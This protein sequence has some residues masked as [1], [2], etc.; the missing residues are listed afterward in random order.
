MFPQIKR[1]GQSR[2]PE[3]PKTKEVNIQIWPYK[4]TKAVV[5]LA[6]NWNRYIVAARLVSL[7]NAPCSLA[8]INSS[9]PSSTSVVFN[10]YSEAKRLYDSL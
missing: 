8:R 4:T 9:A 2:V 5:Q 7:A 3:L 1:P 10:N 6:W